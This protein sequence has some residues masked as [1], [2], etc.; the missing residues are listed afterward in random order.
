[1]DSSSVGSAPELT[2]SLMNTPN[3][4]QTPGHGRGTPPDLQR[5]LDEL[6]FLPLLELE[7]QRPDPDPKCRGRLLP[8]SVE[9]VERTN[10]RL[11]LDVFERAP[12]HLDRGAVGTHALEFGHHAG[13]CFE[14]LGRG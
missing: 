6:E 11:A 2:S 4:S 3:R 8:V 5:R 12:V 14:V 10:D 7:A 9:A 1:M 13:R